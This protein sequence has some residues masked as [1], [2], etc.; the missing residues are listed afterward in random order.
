[1]N[2]EPADPKRAKSDTKKGTRRRPPEIKVEESHSARHASTDKELSPQST[3]ASTTRRSYISNMFF[4]AQTA[5]EF[6]RELGFRFDSLQDNAKGFFKKIILP[7]TDVVNLERHEAALDAFK[8]TILAIRKKIDMPA[9]NMQK[10][11]AHH[12]S[13]T[14]QIIHLERALPRNCLM[15]LDDYLRAGIIPSNFKEKIEDMSNQRADELPALARHHKQFHHDEPHARKLKKDTQLDLEV[16]GVWQNNTNGQGERHKR[17][18][19]FLREVTFAIALLHDYV[20][21][22]EKNPESPYKSNEEA[23]ADWVY[24]WL[25]DILG[26]PLED[27]RATLEQNNIKKL[28][29]L[30]CYQMIVGGTTLLMG[31]LMAVLQSDET[32]AS[33]DLIELQ[34]AVEIVLEETRSE[35]TTS[36]HNE[37]L[38]GEIKQVA[39]VLGKND[40]TPGA[41]LIH[42]LD[43]ARN[44][45]IATLPLVQTY[46]HGA[47]MLQGFFEH[48]FTAYFSDDILKPYYTP[49]DEA[50]FGSEAAFF[51]AVNQ[52]AF[53]TSFT[54]HWFMPPE[55]MSEERAIQVRALSDFIKLCREQYP[56]CATPLEFAELFDS[57]FMENDIKAIMEQV[58]FNPNAIAFEG[59]FIDSQ[60]K[61][62]V[63]WT[64]E[65]EAAGFDKTLIYSIANPDA[66]VIDKQNIV[67]LRQYYDSMKQV[68]ARSDDDLIKELMVG[69]VFSEGQ[70]L[71][72]RRQALQFAQSEEKDERGISSCP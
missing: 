1:M 42:A 60:I 34:P 46:C 6:A 15:L 72:Y 48:Y 4:G 5:K 10:L 32:V 24:Q 49:E 18:D 23:T 3:S 37:I 61:P 9:K 28:L 57:A 29:Q 14:L 58:F 31:D 47:S 27:D 38:I 25:V 22:N 17:R 36:A 71:A 68:I 67:E 39:K 30:M 35:V 11:Q 21:K 16:L 26:M 2:S 55:F 69:V 56:L 62:L 33:M 70:L 19:E 52:Q 7:P 45:A 53:F 64:A 12:L 20:Q 51:E 50:L 40:K 59:R 43:Q 44:Q 54:P 63:R 13:Q 41:A 66:L 8:S 65:F